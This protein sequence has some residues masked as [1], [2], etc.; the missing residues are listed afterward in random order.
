[1]ELTWRCGDHSGTQ[2]YAEVSSEPLERWKRLSQ[3]SSKKHR[4]P[5]GSGVYNALPY[6]HA[7]KD[8][9]ER[10][11]KL[12]ASTVV[13]SAYQGENHGGV[14]I[15]DLH[16]EAVEQVIRYNE[17]SISWEG[18]G[19]PRGLRGIAF[20]EDEIYLAASDEIFVYSKDFRLLR[21]IQNEYLDH[22]HETYL[23]DA[24]LY[25]TSTGRDSV[26]EYDLHTRSFVKGHHVWFRG[27]KRWLKAM[28]FRLRGPKR[29]HNMMGL[30]EAV[31]FLE[32]MPRL[33][34]FDPN[35]DKGPPVSSNTCHLNSVSYEGGLLTVSGT[36]CAHLLTISGSKLASH[37]R[38]PYGTHNA[39]PF[40]E[41]VLL[42]DTS[43]NRVSYLGRD[44]E[45]V[46]FP[47]KHYDEGQLLNSHLPQDH[48]R[49]AF[50]RGLCVLGEGL[51][52][53]GS[54][55]A[56]VSVYDLN[57]SQTLKTINLT[58]DVRN[59]IHG[60]EVWPF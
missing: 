23:N 20:Y 58:M 60:L 33:Q 12:I 22:C 50:G 42:N 32:P 29:R 15:I 16:T 21:S 31:G 17:P 40:G 35:S 8:G 10:L 14:Y 39:R 28:G 53:G 41:G 2:R 54:S 49:Q 51:I 6:K 36:R 52:A 3:Q 48:A 18:R 38:I 45:S 25:V 11:P 26:L 59:T 1:V 55:P 43:S 47:I 34:V 46:T 4:T 57:S 30:R 37:A 19:G 56:T 5:L 7:A 13:R 9:M 44:G 24:T 27:P